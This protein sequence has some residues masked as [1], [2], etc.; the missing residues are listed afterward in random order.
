MSRGRILPLVGPALL[1]Y[2]VVDL[3]TTA[4]A[5]NVR[6][7]AA[8]LCLLVLAGLSVFPLAPTDEGEALGATRLANL[9]L[10]SG[11]LLVGHGGGG[12]VE[13]RPALDAHHLVLDVGQRGL[14]LGGGGQ[15]HQQEQGD[16]DPHSSGSRFSS[17]HACVTGPRRAAAIRPSRSIRK[18]SG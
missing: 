8:G 10:F 5:E 18:V 9:S 15:A 3:V 13:R 14:W 4:G 6:I 1:L 12:D 11:A 16:Q 17:S 7:D 2:L